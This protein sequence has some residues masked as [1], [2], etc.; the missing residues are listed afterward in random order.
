MK[1]KLLFLR[2]CMHRSAWLLG[3][4]E[5]AVDAKGFSRGV[6]VLVSANDS[7]LLRNTNYQYRA[8]HVLTILKDF[9]LDCTLHSGT[10]L[11]VTETEAGLS[12][13]HGDRRNFAGI[14][15][16]LLKSMN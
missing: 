8:S 1:E 14:T 16:I 3:Q 10:C 2:S 5:K 6:P 9:V 13:K 15:M 7:T 4:C 12:C 11:S